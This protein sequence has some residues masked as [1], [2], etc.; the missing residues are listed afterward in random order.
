MTTHRRNNNT[1]RRNL[2][3]TRKVLQLASIEIVSCVEG[4]YSEE[5]DN[6]EIVAD[7]VVNQLAEDNVDILQILI[8][9]YPLMGWILENE[10]GSFPISRQQI[11]RANI[12]ATF[13]ENRIT[14]SYNPS[15]INS[16]RGNYNTQNRNENNS[17]YWNAPSNNHGSIRMNNSPD[18]TNISSNS[19]NSGNIYEQLDTARCIIQFFVSRVFC[20]Y[21][22][23]FPELDG[24]VI[25]EKIQ[26]LVSENVDVLQIVLHRY[27]LIAWILVNESNSRFDCLIN[28]LL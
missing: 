26:Q 8:T 14:R 9:R 16:Y 22:D 6:N 4:H 23:T 25:D 11:S 24:R 27:P 3:A 15:P 18:P 21:L 2:T 17:D 10:N 5:I 7:D 1:R 19:G 20:Y 28:N 13:N 12:S